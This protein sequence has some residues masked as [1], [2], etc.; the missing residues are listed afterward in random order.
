MIFDTNFLAALH[1][2]N[3]SLNWD[4]IQSITE[5]GIITKKGTSQCASLDTVPHASCASGEKLSFDVIIFATGFTAVSAGAT[6]N[7]PDRK[8]TNARRQDHYPLSVIGDTGK[9]VQEYY[10]SQGGPKAYL[11]TTVPGFPNLFILAG[12]ELSALPISMS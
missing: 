8:L 6:Q 11:G 1:R 7:K 4:G 5:D 12:T 10:D 9:T 3:L 2:P